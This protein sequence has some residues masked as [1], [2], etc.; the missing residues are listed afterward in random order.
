[1][2]VHHLKNEEYSLAQAVT[3]IVRTMA[4]QRRKASLLRALD[5]ARAASAQSVCF[6]VVVNG[7]RRAPDV[8][9]ALEAMDDVLMVSLTEASL[10]QALIVGRQ[11]V[12]TPFYC[13]LD[14]DDEF[15]PGAIDIRLAPMLID[16][17]IDIVTTNGYLNTEGVDTIARKHMDLICSQPLRALFA[18]NWLSSCSFMFRSESVG[19]QYFEDIH[20]YVEWTWLAFILILD[21]RK[22]TVIDEPTFRVNNTGGSASKSFEYTA[23]H[24]SLYRRM[25]SRS[26]PPEVKRLIRVRIGD[27][28]HAEAENLWRINKIGSAW[29][30]HL[31]SLAYPGGLRYLTFS[32]R[33][34]SSAD[35]K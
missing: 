20:P 32:R 17:T 22:I 14:D 33:L 11:N 26:P 23:A 19:M 12:K 27:L 31:R 10:I 5:S 21:G 3:V 16:P 18:G 7:Q 35:K 1:M 24:Q 15:L 30:V 28:L 34:L 2:S 9:R 29:R 6:V 13:C 4:D 8:I 25:L